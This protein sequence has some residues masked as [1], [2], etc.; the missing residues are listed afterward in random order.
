M[1]HEIAGGSVAVFPN[2]SA[3]GNPKVAKGV[4]DV[5]TLKHLANDGLIIRRTIVVTAP[6]FDYYELTHAGRNYEQ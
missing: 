2:D 4:T 3:P 6:G 5:G 1:R